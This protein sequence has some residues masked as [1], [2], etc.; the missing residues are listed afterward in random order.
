MAQRQESSVIVSIEELLREAH[1]REE[2]ERRNAEESL[3]AA[4]ERRMEDLRQQQQ[5]PT[6]PKANGGHATT[7]AGPTVKRP[8]PPSSGACIKGDPLCATIE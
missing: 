8:V 5:A 2:Q 1:V 4:H 3:R 6:T 7:P